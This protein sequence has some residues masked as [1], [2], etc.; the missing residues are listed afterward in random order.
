MS[1]ECLHFGSCTRD[2]E[3]MSCS[4]LPEF[5]ANIPRCIP[6]IAC[7]DIFSRSVVLFFST[8]FVALLHVRR[9]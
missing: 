1:R 6:G 7:R 8:L 5:V 3:N 9:P 4:L 2:V